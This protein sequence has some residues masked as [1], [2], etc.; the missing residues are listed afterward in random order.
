MILCEDWAVDADNPRRVNI[1]GLL[2]NI[3]S[4]DQP[5]FPLLYRELCVFLF[6]TE[7]RGDGDARIT[8]IFEESG[9]RIFTTPPRRIGFG[10]NPLDVVG[11]PFRIRDCPFPRPGVYSIQFWYNQE[12]VL[13]QPLRLR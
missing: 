10:R 1:L 7:G 13:E 6:L 8:C 12:L 2:T 4:D 11:V 3:D 5:R 9:Q